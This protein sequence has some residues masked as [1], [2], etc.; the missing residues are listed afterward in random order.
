M[1]NASQIRKHKQTNKSSPPPSFFSAS[2][3][4]EDQKNNSLNV[5]GYFQPWTRQLVRA[6]RKRG[7]ENKKK[8]RV[9]RYERLFHTAEQ[10]CTKFHETTFLC[11]M[12]G[13]TPGPGT[14]R[15]ATLSSVQLCIQTVLCH[16]PLRQQY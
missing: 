12:S 16:P 10:S 9:T 13:L 7:R 5:N 8:T 6:G 14:E 11:V 2:N 1:Q 4:R 3:H 15:E